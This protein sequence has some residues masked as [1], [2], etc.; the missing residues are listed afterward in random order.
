MGAPTWAVPGPSSLKGHGAKYLKALQD[1]P[2]HTHIHLCKQG[3]RAGKTDL[4]TGPSNTESPL[5]DK[6]ELDKMDG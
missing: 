6:M 1:H 2:L 5:R 3:N 4:P